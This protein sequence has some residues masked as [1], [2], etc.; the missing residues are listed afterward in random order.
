MKRF[1]TLC[2]I[3]AMFATTA[4]ADTITRRARVI[5]SEPVHSYVDNTVEPIT[6]CKNVDIPIYGQGSD[7]AGAFIGGAIIGSIIGNAASSANGAGA[8]GAILGGAF[9][10]EHQ[11][12]HHQR[13]VGYRQ[14]RQCTTEYRVVETHRYPT[15]CRTVV[16]IPSMD[17]YRFDFTEN[18]CYNPG[19]LI[20]VRLN[21]GITH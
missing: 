19:E 8:L 16:E 11:K 5:K 21:V 17:R 3:I 13:I 14:E 9:A 4:G 15:R 6:V 2:S 12:K 18:K 1:I 7:D 10:N 20:T